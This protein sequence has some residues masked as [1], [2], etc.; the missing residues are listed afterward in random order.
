MHVRCRPSSEVMGSIILQ[1]GARDVLVGV[2]DGVLPGEGWRAEARDGAR[3]PWSKV[4][5]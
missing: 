1:M 5:H 4:V 3:E 2:A